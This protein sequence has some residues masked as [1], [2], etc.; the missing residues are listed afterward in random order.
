M[1]ISYCFR[2]DSD[3]K[4]QYFPFRTMAMLASLGTTISVSLYS[5]WLFR[6][7]KLQPELD[8][9]GCVVNIPPDSLRLPSDTSFNTS[10]ISVNSEM[11]MQR[12]ASSV[13]ASTNGAVVNGGAA[14]N[15]SRSLLGVGSNCMFHTVDAINF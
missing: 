7:G 2:Y 9:L 14:Q 3:S 5:R 13:N 12:V 6:S 8:V 10:T 15:G 4:V 11:P 1:I